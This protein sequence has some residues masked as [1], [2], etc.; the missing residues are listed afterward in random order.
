MIADSAANPFDL[1]D[2]YISPPALA[3]RAG[4]D[5]TKDQAVLPPAPAG[6][7]ICRRQHGWWIGSSVCIPFPHRPQQISE[8]EKPRPSLEFERILRI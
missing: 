5:V 3:N 6:D 4:H 8:P 7:V 2:E 1:Q